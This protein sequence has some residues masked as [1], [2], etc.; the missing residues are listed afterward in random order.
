MRSETDMNQ[1]KSL[2]RKDILDSRVAGNLKKVNLCEVATVDAALAALLL[3]CVPCLLI[4]YSYKDHIKSIQKDELNRLLN[5][6]TALFG[7][8]YKYKNLPCP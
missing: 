3:Q 8:I 5:I 6:I 1:N 4:D 2:P 7:V